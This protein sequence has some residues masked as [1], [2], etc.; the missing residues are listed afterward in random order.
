MHTGKRRY[1]RP[2]DRPT[3]VIFDQTLVLQGYQSSR[4]RP[5]QG[6]SR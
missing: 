3:G 4:D 1:S 6:Y 5:E 2:A